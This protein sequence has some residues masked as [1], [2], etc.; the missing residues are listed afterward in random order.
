MQEW[1]TEEKLSS[2]AR[3]FPW[4]YQKI[5]NQWRSPQIEDHFA[6]L[7][8]AYEIHSSADV[9]PNR[10][11]NWEILFDYFDVDAPTP[12][13]KIIEQLKLAL[14]SH[15][16]LSLLDLQ[17]EPFRFQADDLL[18]AIVDG[19]V[20][21]DLNAALISDVRNFRVYRDNILVEFDKSIAQSRMPELENSFSVT[22][23]PGIRF[24]F[25]GQVYVI[26]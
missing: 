23:A 19:H 20:A 1:K 16:S 22:L 10:T 2:L 3:K 6:K 13:P 17:S 15:G 12:S 4:R 11:K 7:G 24:E 14:R 26:F 21:C 18:K 25:D 8:V 5:G 9:H